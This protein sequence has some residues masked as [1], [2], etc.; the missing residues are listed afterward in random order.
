MWLKNSTPSRRVRATCRLRQQELADGDTG[1]LS[2]RVMELLANLGWSSTIAPMRRGSKRA[3]RYITGH[4]IRSFPWTCK[5]AILSRN[6]EVETG[7]IRARDLLLGKHGKY[8]P[9]EHFLTVQLSYFQA[10]MILQRALTVFE[11]NP[12]LHHFEGGTVGLHGERLRLSGCDSQLHRCFVSA[13]WS[14]LRAAAWLAPTIAWLVKFIR[15]G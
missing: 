7:N 6:A 9:G 14:V 13:P 1:R 2:S 4:G 12:A 11:S 8:G 3:D 10:H 5:A 15:S